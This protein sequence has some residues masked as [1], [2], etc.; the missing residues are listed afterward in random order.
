MKN[1]VNFS[2]YKKKFCESIVYVGDVVEWHD[3]DGT[4]CI[5]KVT[6]I[7]YRKIDG[8]GFAD[9]AMSLPLWEKDEY[10]VHLE[11]G[12]SVA[13][14]AVVRKLVRKLADKKVKTFSPHS[15]AN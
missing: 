11:D 10:V 8:Y 15:R 1:V 9:V 6:K 14:V 13:G 2:E 3:Y 12:M 7:E 4:E 5:G